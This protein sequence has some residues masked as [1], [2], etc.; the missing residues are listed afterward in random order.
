MAQA[1]GRGA[2][3]EAG[4]RGWW[5]PGSDAY[6]VKEGDKIAMEHKAVWQL[7]MGREDF[8]SGRDTYDFPSGVHRYNL[9]STYDSKTIRAN[10]RVLARWFE[11]GHSLR[12]AYHEVTFQHTRFFLELDEA[13][14][15]LKEDGKYVIEPNLMRLVVEAFDHYGMKLD[16]MHAIATREDKR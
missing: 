11:N 2:G 13:A 3:M 5:Y 10:L 8:L 1:V 12:Y 15:V 7:Q 16:R 4:F 6:Q 9:A 14:G